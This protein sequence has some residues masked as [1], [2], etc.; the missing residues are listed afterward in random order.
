M[1]GD[2]Q[3]LRLQ[4]GVQGDDQADQALRG[5][6]VGTV[7]LAQDKQLLHEYRGSANLGMMACGDDQGCTWV[8]KLPDSFTDNQDQEPQN[9]LP[10]GPDTVLE[11]DRALIR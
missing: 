5:G 7:C 10:I 9:I 3:D 8:Y 2:G 1:R 11:Q 6:G 4:G